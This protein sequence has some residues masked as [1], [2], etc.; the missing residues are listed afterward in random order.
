[1]SCVS[2]V[3]AREILD[4]R[5]NP[6]IEVTLV[7]EDGSTGTASVPSGA[8]TGTFEAIELRDGDKS[9]YNGKGV[10]KAIKNIEEIIANEL[11]GFP[12]CAQWSLDSLLKQ[13][14]GTPNKSRLGANAILAVSL[15]YARASAHFLKV[16]LYFYIGG[17]Q[18]RTMPLP[19]MNIINGG[20]HADSGLDIQEF[21]IVPAG[22]PNF[23]EA[24]RYGAETYHALKEILKRRGLSTSV[25]DEGGFAPHLNGTKEAIECILEAI[26]KA[27]HKP[28]KDIF[29]AL[30]SAATEFFRD[31]KYHI[32]GKSL[33]AD[34]MI[35]FYEELLDKYPIVSLEDPLAEEDWDGYVRLTKA[36]GNRVQIV[37]DDIFVTNIERLKKGIELGVCNAIL[38]KL[39]QIGTLSE[40]LETI[41]LARQYG[42]KTVISHRSGETEDTFI[43]D[44]AVGTNA[45]QIKTGS[46]ARS[47]RLAKYNRLIAIEE[48]LSPSAVF[49]G[50]TMY[51]KFKSPQSEKV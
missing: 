7:L 1:M 42:Y 28:G 36:L 47:E 13:L 3:F 8:S 20:V 11:E 32:D 21:L 26:E 4:S 35:K 51:P 6:T 50:M 37:G 19:M 44:L 16:P 31:S 39:N 25:G 43:A 38:I 18:A 17:M 22:A 12:A 9:R 15:A 30:D 27:G 40:T 48:D 10:L 29:L 49:V 41:D 5:G 23:S 14:D 46:L 2:D 33:D 34:G 45:G 24:L